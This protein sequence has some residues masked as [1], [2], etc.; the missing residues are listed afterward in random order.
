VRVLLG[1]VLTV[2]LLIP[3]P[4]HAAT[5]LPAC[6]YTDVHTKFHEYTDWDRTL[7]DTIYRISSSY[8]PSTLTTSH[9]GI[10]GG[11]TVR[12]FVRPQL[13]AL[14]EA[15]TRAG[16]PLYVKSAYR[17]YQTQQSTFNYWVSVVGYSEALKTSARPG[18]SEHQLGTT[19]D[20][21]HAYGVAPW[22]WSDWATT[23]TGAWLKSNAWRYGWIMSY[24]KYKSSVTCYSY[25]PWHYRYVGVERAK[26]IRDS[27][28]TLREWLWYRAGHA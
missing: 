27:G 17:S 8:A 4:A 28:L 23:R 10:S 2:L 20:F 24:P 16:I 25:E 26:A 5:P 15:A 18:H 11:G 19:I 21:T 22:D 7:L 12:F 9:A 14:K 13:R 6:R 1:I 3:G